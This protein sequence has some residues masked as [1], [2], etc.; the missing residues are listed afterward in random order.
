MVKIISGIVWTGKQ[1]PL[2]LEIIFFFVMVNVS[3][4]LNVLLT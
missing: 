3:R 1:N 2:L 4:L